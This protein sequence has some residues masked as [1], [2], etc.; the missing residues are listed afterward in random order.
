LKLLS[1]APR[2][3]TAKAF[4]GLRASSKLV[5]ADQVQVS[6]AASQELFCPC[7]CVLSQTAE[8]PLGQLTQSCF[9]AVPRGKLELQQMVP[10]QWYRFN[11]WKEH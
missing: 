3:S 8:R 6:A 9:V 4:H 1:K 7:C 10:C 2:G 11:L 5:Y